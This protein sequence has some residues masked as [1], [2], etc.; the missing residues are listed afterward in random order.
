MGQ[1]ARAVALE[2]YSLQSAVARFERLFAEI[3]AA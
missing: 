2:R 1:R 3:Q